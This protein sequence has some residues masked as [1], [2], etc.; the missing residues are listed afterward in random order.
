[1]MRFMMEKQFLV[2]YSIESDQD[3]GNDPIILEFLDIKGSTGQAG[4]S[5]IS[6]VDDN[7]YVGL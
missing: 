7:H 3:L 5:T 1:M 2:T 4:S 6:K